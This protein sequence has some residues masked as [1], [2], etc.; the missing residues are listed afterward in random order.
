MITTQ[1]IIACEKKC[2]T[3]KTGSISFSA[4][5]SKIR[6]T[7]RFSRKLT[8]FKQKSFHNDIYLTKIV[9]ALSI[10]FFWCLVEKKH[11][12]KLKE[13]KHYYLKAKLNHNWLKNA[14]IAEFDIK[15]LK[16]LW[17]NKILKQYLKSLVDIFGKSPVK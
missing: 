3:L 7:W 14:H 13:T 10:Y 1:L 16:S 11:I 8:Q 9:E 2:R 12:D 17:Q 4:Q 5:L 15:I 6:L